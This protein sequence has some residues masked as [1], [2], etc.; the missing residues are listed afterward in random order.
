MVEFRERTAPDV[1]LERAIV[2]VS[3]MVLLAA[4]FKVGIG[5]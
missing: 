3:G 1:P 5:G 4:L 2:S